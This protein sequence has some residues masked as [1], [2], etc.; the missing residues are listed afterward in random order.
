MTTDDSTRLPGAT[1]QRPGGFLR[2]LASDYKAFAS[3]VGLL[4]YGVV[5][6]AYDAFYSRLG[7]FPEAVGL[8]ETTI[9]GRAVLYLALTVS[10]TAIFVGLWLLA[11]GTS[12]ERRR[13]T[14]RQYLPW[15]RLLLLTAL[16]FPLVAFVIV[17]AGPRLRSLLD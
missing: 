16:V 14:E 17:V 6:V 1:E 2:T 8:S 3:L 9:L 15:A 5:R 4:I 13:A 12:L 11:V 10:V 7:V